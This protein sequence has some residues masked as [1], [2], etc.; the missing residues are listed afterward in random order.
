MPRRDGRK[1]FLGKTRKRRKTL[2][3]NDRRK[4]RNGVVN[5]SNLSRGGRSSFNHN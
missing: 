4:Q 1:R 2:H 5:G 3:D